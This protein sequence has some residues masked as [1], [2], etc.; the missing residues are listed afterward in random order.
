MT[1]IQDQPPPRDALHL[2]ED[3]DPHRR[4]GVEQEPYGDHAVDRTVPKG[5]GLGVA[6][7]KGKPL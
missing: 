6:S 2:A 3:P 5:Q 4:V 7:D 1:I